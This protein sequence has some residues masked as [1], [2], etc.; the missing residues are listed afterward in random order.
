MPFVL[1]YK[2]V[3]L[4]CQWVDC[5]TRCTVSFAVCDQQWQQTNPCSQARPSKAIISR[6]RCL[7]RKSHKN[8]V[9]NLLDQRLM[10]SSVLRALLPWL[11]GSHATL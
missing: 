2:F 7:L 6:A 9:L 10:P 4:M 11:L 3:W 1:V 8:E 5:I